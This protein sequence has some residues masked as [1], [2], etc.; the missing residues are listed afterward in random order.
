MDESS[1]IFPLDTHSGMRVSSARC[2]KFKQRS[3]PEPI[4][5]TA[6]LSDIV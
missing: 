5:V 1:S 2:C 3:K 4:H 6:S